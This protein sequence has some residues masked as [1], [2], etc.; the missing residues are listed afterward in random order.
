MSEEKT[1]SKPS[2]VREFATEFSRYWVEW[3]HKILFGCLFTAWVLL[4]DHFG[5]ST[6]GYMN[7]S[8]IFGWLEYCYYNSEDDSFGRWIPVIVLGLFWW[9][10]KELKESVTAPWMGGLF[11][12]LVAIAIHLAGFLIQQTRIS[13]IGFLLGLYALLGLAWGRKLMWASTFP[14]VLLIFCVPL[15]T[16]AETITFPMRILITKLSVGVAHDFLGIEVFRNGSQIMNAKGVALYDV[17]PACSGIRSLVTLVALSSIYGFTSFKTWWKRP[18]IVLL[19]LPLAI[20][21][22]W[23]RV[24]TVIVVGEAFGLDYGLM[25]EQ[26]FGFIT[27]AVSLGLLL[28]IGSFLR[29]ENATNTPRPDQTLTPNPA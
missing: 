17:A 2:L 9:K 23:V 12:L 16:L 7:T 28:F 15:N 22:N 4:F 26:K 13:M 6:L 18:F 20:L 1:E 8:S 27:F 5:N 21:G 19:S 14:M 25:I 3:P 10:R 24:T 29:E 11:I